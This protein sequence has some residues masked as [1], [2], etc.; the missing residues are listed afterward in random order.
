MWGI[1][2]ITTV[3]N[4]TTYK[5]II[6]QILKYCIDT[7]RTL[8]HNIEENYNHKQSLKENYEFD[9]MKLKKTKN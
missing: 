9:F 1:F 3:P 7:L 4:N 2:L 8:P 6:A 5:T